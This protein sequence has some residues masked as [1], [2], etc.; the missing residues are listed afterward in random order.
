MKQINKIGNLRITD[1]TSANLIVH[2]SLKINASSEKIWEVVSDHTAFSKWMPMVSRVEVNDAFADE[3]G[4]G[5]ERVCTFGKD[6]IQEK[7]I[8]IEKNNV[9]GYQAE[10][11][12]MFKNHLGVV[13]ISK[14]G[15]KTV[16]DYYVFFNPVG[17]KGFMMKNIML[18]IVLKKALK[19]LEGIS[20][21]LK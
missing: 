6:K 13:E 3:N 5:C 20:T 11:T 19:N 1:F 4:N 10:D 2:K 16:V 14:K 18:P 12:P 21:S 9:F 8:H 15:Q 17:M 7:V